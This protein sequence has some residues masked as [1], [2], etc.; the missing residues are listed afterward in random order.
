MRVLLIDV[1]C[2][3][4]STGKIVYDLFKSL[5]AGGHTA[6]ICY[7]RGENVKEE[8]IYKFGLDV[9][10]KIHAVLARITGL[11]GYFSPFSTLRLIKYIKKFKPEVV[12]IHELHAYF[13]NFKPL[14]KY[15][16]KAKIKIVW[17][18]HCEYMYTGKCGHA[19][20]CEQWKLE[21]GHCPAVKG[22]P[23]S[24][25]LDFTKKMLK[26]KKLLLLDTDFTIVTPSRWL[27]ERVK[28]SFLKDK[29]I[30][31]I[32][33]G[34]EVN[35]TFYPRTHSEISL[36]K[37]KYHMENK[38]IVLS[39]APKI[40]SDNKGGSFI[41]E[42]SKQ[43][44]D[45]NIHFVLVG[46]ETT[47]KI[48]ENVTAIKKITNQNEL[49]TWYSAAELF[50]ICSR[51]ETFSMTCAEAMCCGT[52]IVGFKSGAPETIFPQPYALFCEYG[53]TEKMG[54]LIRAQ[55][56]KNYDKEK[57]SLCGKELFDKNIMYSKYFELYKN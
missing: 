18:F 4:S 51:K 53:C 36:L 13:V 10:T 37:E 31:V 42:V 43:F 57:I 16:K 12:H 27:A 52:P 25:F 17:T 29:K 7:G 19:Y 49:A 28:L 6:A 32:H 56:E 47:E 54:D 23:Q 2:K 9:E 50:L 24:L 30:V 46:A 3:K 5:N 38:K 45:K 40:M 20:E 41:L 48:G 55:L 14:L 1:N 8:N 34:I 22:Y 15:L 11:N 35:E 39:V 33:N 44:K 26:D 21:C